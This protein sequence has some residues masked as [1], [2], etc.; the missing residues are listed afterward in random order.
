[1]KTIRTATYYLPQSTSNV[2]CITF[3]GDHIG[4]RNLAKYKMATESN[5]VGKWNLGF[6]SNM[7]VKHITE[8]KGVK[9]LGKDNQGKTYRVTTK[10]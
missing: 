5:K 6:G 9:I 2:A 7:N 1:M 4:R 3:L 10:D 8:K